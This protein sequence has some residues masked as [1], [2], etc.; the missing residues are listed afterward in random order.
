A[1]DQQGR[2]PRAAAPL[3]VTSPP[4]ATRYPMGSGSATTAALPSTSQGLSA[5]RLALAFALG[6]LCPLLFS[7]LEFTPWRAQPMAGLLVLLVAVGMSAHQVSPPGRGLMADLLVIGGL[8]VLFLG[9]R[10]LVEAQGPAATA[11][12]A[13]RQA[14]V[15][16]GLAA[17]LVVPI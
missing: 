8:G 4:L 16:W 13:A 6:L 5:R 12:L 11:T 17:A 2:G 15:Q 1:W 9:L 10:T 7:P 14:A 3:G